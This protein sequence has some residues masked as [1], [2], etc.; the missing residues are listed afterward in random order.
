[1]LSGPF[2]GAE[3]VQAGL[4][5]KHE[6]RSRYFALFPG[7]YLPRGTQPAFAQRVQAAWLWSHR[8]GVVAGLT[9]SRLFG[10]KWVDEAHPIELV[11]PNARP[12][13]GI[14]T[15]ATWLADGEVVSLSGLPTTS[16]T[17][18]AFDLAR[19]RP[20]SVAI[21][22]LDALGNASQLN[23]D[24]ILELSDRHTGTRGV[25]QVPR[26]LDLHD[27]G[28][29]SPKETWLRLLVIGGSFP[30]PRT[31]IPVRGRSG[32][33]YYLDMGWEH[34]KIAVEYDGDQHRTSPAQFARDIFRL[35]EVAALGW[36]VV[37]VVAGT[38]PAA[39]IRRVQAAWAAR[40]ASTLR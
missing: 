20:V 3:A 1:M 7:V 18:T 30:R 37:R 22:R 21:A 31:Q 19:R 36:I 35:E 24:D 13:R 12:P 40:T 39:V 5:R 10:A 2:V 33:Q 38:P 17:R 4:V 29:Q 6:L 28:A 15:S 9:A 32:R 16:L 25:R 27:R 23:P 14:T 8:Q 11:W 26:I 34:L